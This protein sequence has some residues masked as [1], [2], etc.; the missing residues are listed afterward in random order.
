MEKAAKTPPRGTGPGPPYRSSSPVRRGPV[1][2]PH[3][4]N[5]Q[6]TTTTTTTKKT[7][8]TTTTTTLRDRSNSRSPS[9]RAGG[10]G[11]SPGQTSKSNRK[12][13]IKRRDSMRMRRMTSMNQ[14]SG[15]AVGLGLGLGLAEE[16]S[17][18]S[19]TTARR[20]W[21]TIKLMTEE[22]RQEAL[23][24]VWYGMI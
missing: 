2:A 19:V 10:G 3:T 1:P 5:N 20:R 6:A 15:G 12:S 18:D 4:T 8:T 11:A 13:G 23:M 16:D 24:Q 7:T 22:M 21:S 9:R 17:E 14:G